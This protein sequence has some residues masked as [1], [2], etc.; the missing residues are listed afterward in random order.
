MRSRHTAMQLVAL[1][2]DTE[3]LVLS[4]AVRAWAEDRIHLIGKQIIVFT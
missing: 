2:Q 1:G 3:R 4:R